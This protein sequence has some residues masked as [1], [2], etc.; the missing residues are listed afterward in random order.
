MSGAKREQLKNTGLVKNNTSHEAINKYTTI[1]KNSKEIFG[2][3]N[4]T[5]YI[6]VNKKT[7]YGKEIKWYCIRTKH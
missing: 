3:L 7:L 5:I 4:F 1:K 2:R 6:C